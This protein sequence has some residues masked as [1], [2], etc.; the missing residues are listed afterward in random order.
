MPMTQLDRPFRLKTPLGDDALLLDSFTGSERVSTPYRYTLRLLAPDPNI[1]MKDLMA[2]PAVLS[3]RLDED[4]ERYIHGHVSR[5]KLLEYGEDGMA[6][7]EAEIVPWLWFLTLYSNCKIF[8]NK[9]VPDILEQVFK[10][11]GFTDYKLNLGSYQPREYCVQYRETDFN[12]V[13]RLMEEEGIFYFFEQTESKHT[14]VLADANKAFV[15]CPNQK[16][17]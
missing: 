13:S 15:P 6:V 9:T 4:K 1:K 11:R 10:D 14:L 8:Q 3:L 16:D 5:M 12:F 2:K 17:A 7:Y